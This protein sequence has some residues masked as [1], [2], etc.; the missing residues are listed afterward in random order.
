M[1]AVTDVERTTVLAEKAVMPPLVETL[2]EEPLVAAAESSTS[3]VVREPGV[4]L[5]LAAGRKRSDVV[6]A[7]KRAEL[8]ERDV[9]MEVQLLPSVDHCQ[10]PC[11]AVAAL[12]VMATPRKLLAEDPPATVSVASEKLA[13]KRALIRAP[14]GLVLSS[15]M[16][17]REA[18]LEATGASLTALT[19]M[20]SD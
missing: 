19:V 16:A 2:M 14:A 11:A 7:R 20:A 3:R 9:A 15:L 18:L 8:L 12:A 17:A 10:V 1:T 6:V 4:P 13:E 5:K